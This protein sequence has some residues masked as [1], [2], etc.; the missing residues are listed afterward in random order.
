MEI[1]HS[2]SQNLFTPAVLFFI[3]G[4]GAGFFKSDLEIPKSISS[5][6]SIYLMMAIGFKGGVAIAAAPEFSTEILQVIVAAI[7]I[8][9]SL[10]V[11]AFF[12]LRRT[13]S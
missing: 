5:Y 2:L 8:G 1:L 6:L 10:P 11:L 4:I 12:L 3:L 13:T 9:V 7:A